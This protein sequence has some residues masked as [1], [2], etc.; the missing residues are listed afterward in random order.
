MTVVPMIDEVAAIWLPRD[1]VRVTGP[2]AA[3]FLQG[4]LSQNIEGDAGGIWSLILQPQGKVDAWVRVAALDD[5]FV[6]DVESGFGQ[7]VVDRLERFLLRVK[8]EVELRPPEDTLHIRGP[9]STK[10]SPLGTHRYAIEWSGWEG[11]DER[12]FTDADRERVGVPL[13]ERE[14]YEEARIR[15]G[16]PSMGAE[17]DERTIPAEVPGLVASSVSFTKGCFTGQELVARIDSRGGNVP[18]HLRV[19]ELDRPAPVGAEVVVGEKVV[20]AVTSSVNSW[21]LAFVGRAVTPPADAVVRFA[22]GDTAATI[23]EVGA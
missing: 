9:G 4:Q 20:G 2:D 13:V 10:G 17:L 8:V 16:W 6:L 5:Q 21:A 3:S 12:G 23:R 22:G 1:I 11:V 15:A 19:L 14:A 7:S 18:R